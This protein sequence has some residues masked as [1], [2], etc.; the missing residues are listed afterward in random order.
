MCTQRALWQCGDSSHFNKGQ[1]T[2]TAGALRALGLVFVI[3]EKAAV[4]FLALSPTAV[5]SSQ[6]GR[7]SVCDQRPPPNTRQISGRG[8]PPAAAPCRRGLH[9]VEADVRRA[10]GGGCPD[11]RDQPAIPPHAAPGDRQPRRRPTDL[12]RLRP[13]PQP[14]LK[15]HFNS[16]P[17][18]SP[19]FEKHPQSR[20]VC[21]VGSRE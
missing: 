5:L 2:A 9:S 3:P 14:K 7:C 17:S 1:W 12:P 6:Q 15:L 4:S 20:A 11:P 21:S 8:S 10:P 13:P 19:W 16:R 18:W